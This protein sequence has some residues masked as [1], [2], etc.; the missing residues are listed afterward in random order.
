MACSAAPVSTEGFLA[1]AAPFSFFVYGTTPLPWWSRLV[2]V[3]YLIKFSTLLLDDTGFWRH[4]GGGRE[5]ANVW[6]AG[7]RR[8]F[9]GGQRPDKACQF[10]RD[11]S[12]NFPFGFSPLQ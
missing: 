6:L 1:V 12:D 8:R 9:Y 10:P 3:V 5:W 7:G 4:L 11:A 2:R